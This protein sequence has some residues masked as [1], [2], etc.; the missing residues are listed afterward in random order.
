MTRPR[1]LGAVLLASVA[2]GCAPAV[3]PLPGPAPA[4]APVPSR[5]PVPATGTSDAAGARVTLAARHELTRYEVRSETRLTVDSAGAPVTET[6]SA[7]A[8]VSFSLERFGDPRSQ[9]PLGLRGSGRVDGF[10]LTPSP[11]LAA[12]RSSAIASDTPPPSVPALPISVTFDAMVDG[13]IARASP[14]PALA[15]ECDRAELGATALARELL[16][17]LPGALAAGDTWTDTTRVFVCR[18]GVPVTVETVATSRVDALEAGETGPAS[19]A[20]ISRALVMRAEGEQ[21]SAWRSLGLVGRGRG[22]QEVR[23]ALPGGVIESLDGT[24][25]TSFVLHDSGRPNGGE[26][27]L[28]QQVTYRAV[29]AA[30]PR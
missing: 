13:L 9:T 7:A 12:A 10:V 18:G 22:R 5:A 15:N 8:S 4:P 29:R 21:A 27:R 1:R 24:S 26:A 14:V 19:I 16:V 17:R 2:I 6:V 11:R 28:T 20:R 3:T 23:V 30:S 25:E